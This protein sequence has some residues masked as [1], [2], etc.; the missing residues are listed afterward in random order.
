MKITKLAFMGFLALIFIACG[1]KEEIKK[2]E[3]IKKQALEAKIDP[4][5]N[6]KKLCN[7]GNITLCYELGKG[8]Y[9]EKKFN[10]ALLYFGKACDLS[11]NADLCFD[12]AMTY[13]GG[14]EVPKNSQ[15]ALEFW[16]KAC[17]L[18]NAEACDNAGIMYDKG[19]GVSQDYVKAHNLYKKGCDLGSGYTCDNVGFAY[20]QG[21]G[22]KK[23]Y[24]K[25]IL[26]K[27]L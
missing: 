19:D 4:K 11:N 2:Q 9:D 26:R 23:N 13:Y 7:E 12:V 1:G 15:K 22:V 8:Y 25:R 3:P 17:S 20:T 16:Q 24:A 14:N 10:E 5:Q 6:E 21:L 27:G 18:G